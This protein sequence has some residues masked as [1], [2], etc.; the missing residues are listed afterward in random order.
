MEGQQG[1]GES[2]GGEPR[3]FSAP[4]NSADQTNADLGDAGPPASPDS[5]SASSSS[6]SN[7]SDLDSATELTRGR[8]GKQNSNANS[9]GLLPTEKVNPLALIDEQGYRSASNSQLNPARPPSATR[10]GSGCARPGSDRHVVLPPIQ[11]DIFA[12]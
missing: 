2:E 6:S 10:P 7:L 4:I 3:A 8:D 9:K 11:N 1:L 12:N 5:S